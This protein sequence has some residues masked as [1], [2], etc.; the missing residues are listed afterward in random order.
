FI[1]GS[2]TTTQTHNYSWSEKLQP[3]VY[4]Y[5][6]KQVDFNGKFE[7]SKEI[8]VIVAPKSFSLEQNYPNPFNPSTT[9]KYNLPVESHIVIKV[10]N[11]L[12]QNVRELN[13]GIKQQGFH[14]LHFNSTGL[15]SGVYLYAIKAI[16]VDGKKDFYSIKKMILMK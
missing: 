3:G 12:G 1:N 4:S 11:S 14:E 7:Y 13:L 15:A 2:G 9:I 6:L 10:Y 16:S 5:Q 8:D